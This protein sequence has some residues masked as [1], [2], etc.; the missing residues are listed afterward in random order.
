MPIIATEIVH[1]NVNKDRS[2]KIK[3]LNDLSRK[4]CIHIPT[5]TSKNPNSSAVYDLVAQL[6]G[7]KAINCNQ[8]TCCIVED[9]YVFV[10]KLAQINKQ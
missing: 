1:I 6:V 7:E 2:I 4:K 9:Y 8:G 5:Y 10:D 3:F